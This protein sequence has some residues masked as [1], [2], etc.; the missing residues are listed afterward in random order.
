MVMAS[1]AQSVSEAIT[2]SHVIKS[3]QIDS[4]VVYA[5]ALPA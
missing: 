3:K 4:V 2:V 1:I 5:L